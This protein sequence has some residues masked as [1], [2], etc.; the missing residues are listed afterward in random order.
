MKAVE[1]PIMQ[2]KWSHM[3]ITFSTQDVN[4]ALL[5]HMDVMVVTVLIDR[6][7]VTKILIDNG[8]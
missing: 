7:D 8:S 6:W 2:T 3:P 5:P 4:L 1:G